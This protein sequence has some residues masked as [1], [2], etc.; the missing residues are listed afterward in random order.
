MQAYTTTLCTGCLLW[1]SEHDHSSLLS[2]GMSA[3]GPLEQREEFLPQTQAGA[4]LCDP[5]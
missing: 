4:V 2:M 5:L 3:F 1:S